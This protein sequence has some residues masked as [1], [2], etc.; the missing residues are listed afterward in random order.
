M[1]TRVLIAFVFL[2]FVGCTERRQEALLDRA[3]MELSEKHYVEATELLRKTIVAD[4]DS[5]PAIKAYYRL[6]FTLETY[7]SDFEGAL[8]AYQQFVNIARIR[9]VSM[10]CSNV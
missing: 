7:L 9:S 4:P 1:S 3:D 6:G 10:R 2:V 8:L 5:K